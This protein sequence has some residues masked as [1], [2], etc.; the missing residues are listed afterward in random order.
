MPAAPGLSAQLQKPPRNTDAGQAR[1]ARH[2]FE[3]LQLCGILQELPHGSRAI[4][5]HEGFLTE[6]DWLLLG[7]AEGERMVRGMEG[8]WSVLQLGEVVLLH[9]LIRLARSSFT[10]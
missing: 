7:N 10:W 3:E 9:L 1:E 2:L 4:V 8:E 5:G 6:G